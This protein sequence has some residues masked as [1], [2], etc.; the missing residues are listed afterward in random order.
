MVPRTVSQHTRNE[1]QV[2]GARLRKLAPFQCFCKEFAIHAFN[3]GSKETETTSHNTGNVGDL[4]HN[5]PAIILQ[6]V[7]RPVGRMEPSVFHQVRSLKK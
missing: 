6:P 5:V 3:M 4:V 1:T 2:S 7:T